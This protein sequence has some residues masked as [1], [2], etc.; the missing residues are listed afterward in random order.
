MVINLALRMNRGVAKSADAR[1]P[2]K[3]G[4]NA[5]ELARA[6]KSGR[7]V[8]RP[9]HFDD[10][11]NTKK[12]SS[13]TMAMQDDYPKTKEVPEAVKKSA[14]KT[15]LKD[16]SEGSSP[17]ANGEAIVDAKKTAKKTLVKQETQNEVERTQRSSRKTMT[18]DS[19]VDSPEPEMTNKTAHRTPLKSVVKN[20]SEQIL[21]TPKKSK[22]NVG[23][24]KKPGI[25]RNDDVEEVKP[26][27]PG[28]SRTGRKIKIPAHLKEFDDVLVLS[29]KKEIAENASARKSIAQV[30]TKKEETLKTPGRSRSLAPL[31]KALEPEPKETKVEPKTPRRGKSL[32]ARKSDEEGDPLAL[33]PSPKK[34]K[35]P[36][37]D[38]QHAKSSIQNKN[39]SVDPLKL[40]EDDMSAINPKR[41][42]LL[43]APEVMK[44]PNKDKVASKTPSKR[45]KSMLIACSPEKPPKTPKHTVSSKLVEDSASSEP[46]SRSGRKIKPKKYFGEFEEEELVGVVSTVIAS[47]VASPVK[48][49]AKSSPVS[50]KEQPVKVSSPIKVIVKSSP[51]V[52]E[53]PPIKLASPV[54]VVLKSPPITKKESPLKKKVSPVKRSLVS[55]SVES[56]SPK[57]KAKLEPKL[58]HSDE[59]KLDE[60]SPNTEERLITKRGV[61]DHHHTTKE[62]QIS[63]EETIQT[64]SPDVKKKEPTTVDK[65]QIEEEKP[66]RGRRTL[67]AESAKQEEVPDVEEPMLT[68]QQQANKSKRGRK[69]LSEPTP[70]SSDESEKPAPS[71]VPKTPTARR[72]TT[73][74]VPTAATDDVGSSRSGRKIKPKKFFGEDEPMSASKPKTAVESNTLAKTAGRGKRKTIAVDLENASNRDDKTDEEIIANDAPVGTDG[75]GRMKT[76]AVELEKNSGSD[77]NDGKTE[78]VVITASKAEVEECPSREEIMAVVGI[79][80]PVVTDKTHM[81]EEKIN[82]HDEKETNSKVEGQ[83]E[84]NVDEPDPIEENLPQESELESITTPIVGTMPEEENDEN[85]SPVMDEVEHI[86]DNDP[87]QIDAPAASEIVQEDQI[88]AVKPEETAEVF[89][90]HEIIK[91]DHVESMEPKD[92]DEHEADLGIIEEDLVDSADL[93]EVEGASNVSQGK[94]TDSCTVGEPETLLSSEKDFQ[95]ISIPQ[96]SPRCSLTMEEVPKSPAQL[97]DEPSV[98]EQSDVEGVPTYVDEVLEN[99]PEAQ[100]AI[101]DDVQ[102]TNQ[103]ENSEASI[104]MSGKGEATETPQAINEEGTISSSTTEIVQQ[105]AELSA[106]SSFSEALLVEDEAA[107]RRCNEVADN[108]DSQYESVE[109]LEM[110]GAST[111]NNEQGANEPACTN[112]FEQ[113]EQVQKRIVTTDLEDDL[114]N[115]EAPYMDDI[116]EEKEDELLDDV[117]EPKD[118]TFSERDRD[119]ESIIVVPDTP[120]P[121]KSE[122]EEEFDV[123]DK[124]PIPQSS[125]ITIGRVELHHSPVMKK[126]V[127]P[128]TPR[129][130]DSKPIKTVCSPDKPDIQEQANVPHEVIDITDSPIA[131]MDPKLCQ[132]DE[133]GCFSSTPLNKGSKMTIKD[134]LIQNSR[135]RSL[136][137]SD[138]EIV[139]KNVT[140]HSPAN[141]TVLADTIDERLKKKNKNVTKLPP[142]HRKRSLS[143]HKIVHP[144]GPKPSK[145]SKLP[146]FKNIHQQQFN[147]M[148]SIE[149]F[150]NRKVQRAKEILTSS[151]SKSPAAKALIRSAERPPMQ[152][153]VNLHQKSPHKTGNGASTSSSLYH[154]ASSKPNVVRPLMSKL[155]E[156]HPHKLPSDAERQEKRQKQFQ[157][158][159]KTKSQD[160]DTESAGTSGKNTSD[161]TRRVI[162]QSR[163]KQNQILKGVRT[164]KRFELLMKYRDA[165]E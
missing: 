40:K 10:S 81:E 145:I 23:T 56:P 63:A 101:E 90:D 44:S 55:K 70:E 17:K 27:V 115:T 118:A 13:V 80:D 89:V 140:F 83:D 105:S 20:I 54:K 135:K 46:M 117:P 103:E 153:S 42:K 21:D 11:P 53:E 94:E 154:H 66:K 151:T 91:E 57:K 39:I 85:V 59:T 75:H 3:D 125:Q 129:T 15:L 74:L 146:N 58:T 79:T 41:G 71:K 77:I 82:V 50:K 157:S 110:S 156:S 30:A 31:Q 34:S 93:E 155:S 73:A 25:V 62:H 4:V 130:P 16:Q 111:A 158:V 12:K 138:A 126:E 9:T 47:K 43:A 165:Q 104:V 32:A 51:V 100:K 95:G 131:V 159:F 37:K 18:I 142:G 86:G 8:K 19:K 116:D 113:E 121:S 136:S 92:V 119:N 150:H 152:K 22:L 65:K 24:P 35:S 78:E 2:L 162:E 7:K 5:G 69:T 144:D 96:T 76:L 98:E 120:R 68:E 49:I 106:C 6:T 14:R 143:E 60:V 149:E 124:S 137:V 102:V 163:H 88:E 64:P 67:A 48:I 87:T 114:D 128:T 52:K 38:N 139:K 147:R 112:G 109:F 36:K 161:G 84:E 45:G 28:V 107:E 26:D 164:N 108:I 99:I 134:E 33:P 127:V 122:L 132:T 148:E 72:A 29:P 133:P 61:N 123:T 141:S 97:H 160:N 1:T